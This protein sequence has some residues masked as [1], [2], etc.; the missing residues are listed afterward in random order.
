MA[1]LELDLFWK[2]EKMWDDEIEFGRR[3]KL[4]EKTQTNETKCRS[5]VC[6]DSGSYGIKFFL[7]VTSEQFEIA[8]KEQQWTGLKAFDHFREVVN[9]DIRVTWDK[10]V[11]VDYSDAANKATENFKIAQD[12]FI[13][14]YLNYTRPQDVMLRFL[15]QACRKAATTPCLNHMHQFKEI[16]RNIRKLPARVKPNP[17]EDELKEWFLRS[18][19]KPHRNTFLTAGHKLEMTT[20]DNICEFMRLRHKEDL[21]NGTLNL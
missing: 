17:I 12:K 15:E 11:D 7:S 10:T 1:Y 20:M 19:F 3:K 2:M 6:P 21:D 8:H 13:M 9:G 18:F 5:E 16:Y 4:F 14:C